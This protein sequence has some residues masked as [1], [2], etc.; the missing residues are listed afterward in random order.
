LFYF[1]G[2]SSV[3]QELKDAQLRIKGVRKISTGS[4]SS[5]SDSRHSLYIRRVSSKLLLRDLLIRF[6][7]VF[8]LFGQSNMLHTF[9]WLIFYHFLQL[10]FRLTPLKSA[11]QK[12]MKN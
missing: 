10:I 7:L 11:A 3:V 1:S 6:K 12:V 4:N 9:D 2:G 5:D 8:G